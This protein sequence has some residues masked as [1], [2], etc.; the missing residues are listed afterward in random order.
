MKLLSF[1]SDVKL[2]RKRLEWYLACTRRSMVVLRFEL[3][4][5]TQKQMEEELDAIKTTYLPK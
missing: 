4:I 2:R 1:P 5:I 3:G